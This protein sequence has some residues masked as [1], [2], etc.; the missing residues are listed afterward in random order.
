MDG[1]LCAADFAH[2]PSRLDAHAGLQQWNRRRSA[3]CSLLLSPA[4]V[5]GN[6]PGRTCV[7]AAPLGVSPRHRGRTRSRVCSSRRRRKNYSS[8]LSVFFSFLFCC[9]TRFSLTR[10]SEVGSGFGVGRSGGRFFSFAPVQ[11]SAVSVQT[12]IRL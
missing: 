8:L 5:S 11:K 7:W 2:C 1:G 10:T 12:T 3:G 9:W 6:R 4:G